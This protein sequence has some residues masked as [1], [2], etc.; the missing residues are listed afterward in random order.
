MSNEGS[1]GLIL[2]PTHPTMA[3]VGGV[4][5]AH[6]THSSP[7][8]EPAGAEPAS[9][10][11]DQDREAACREQVLQGGPVRP[12]HRV[13]RAAR[14]RLSLLSFIFN[15]SSALFSGRGDLAAQDIFRG[16]CPPAQR[17]VSVRAGVEVRR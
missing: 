4:F 16:T 10:Q 12:A 15:L 14:A 13:R 1:V 2:Y 17:L 11:T 8:P 6:R 9:A 3:G 5:V 7:D